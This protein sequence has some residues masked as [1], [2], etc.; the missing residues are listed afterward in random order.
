[1]TKKRRE[2]KNKTKKIKGKAD[3]VLNYKLINCIHVLFLSYL[4]MKKNLKKI[5]LFSIL[6]SIIFYFLGLI[7]GIKIYEYLTSKEKYEILKEIETLR[8]E[9][10]NISS[11]TYECD[12]LKNYIR[13]LK[14]QLNSYRK[15]LPY[16]LEGKENLYDDLMTEYFKLSIVAW[17]IFKE[18]EK[19]N[20]KVKTFLYFID[21][22][23]NLCIKQGEELDKI[24]E[25]L[26][27]KGFECEIFVVG[28]KTNYSA[29]NEIKNEFNISSAPFLIFNHQ[30]FSFIS[31]EEFVNEFKI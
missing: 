26:R 12:F 1:L 25:Y 18:Y 23:C 20:E 8:K 2:E 30:T 6:F 3:K 21:E 29:I 19:C 27:N 13:I 11:K 17:K 22:K 9:F 5:F 24:K 16:R 10:E 15:F 31:F 4:F 28:L 14:I 7:S